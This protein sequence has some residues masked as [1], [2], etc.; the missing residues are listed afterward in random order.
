MVQPTSLR[1]WKTMPLMRA[2]LV[3]DDGGD[4]YPGVFMPRR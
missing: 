1:H 2:V 4:G 3:T